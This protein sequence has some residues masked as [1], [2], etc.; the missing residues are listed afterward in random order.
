[1]VE[2]MHLATPPLRREGNYYSRY[3]KRP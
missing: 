3:Y 1:V 2:R